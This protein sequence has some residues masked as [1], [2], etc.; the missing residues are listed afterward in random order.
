MNAPKLINKMKYILF[1][2]SIIL[3]AFSCNSNT[4]EGKNQKK[5]RHV[6]TFKFKDDV[7]KEQ[8]EKLST[9]FVALEQKIPAIKDFEGGIIDSPE[10]LHQDFTHSFMI[11]FYS[12]KD[13][14][15]GY[16]LHPAHDAF[17]KTLLPKMEKI[18]VVDYWTND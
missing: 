15:E 9:D 10:D 4:A 14:D 1:T 8:I 2:F 17:V 5:L 13:R 16:T 12:E 3:F 7:T 11:T 6:V 18:F